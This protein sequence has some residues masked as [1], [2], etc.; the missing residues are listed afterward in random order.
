[1]NQ[2][3]SASW[4][5]HVGSL[6]T[7]QQSPNWIAAKTQE[8]NRGFVI[9][10]IEDTSEGKQ[11]LLSDTG[12]YYEVETRMESDPGPPLMGNLSKLYHFTSVASSVKWVYTARFRR[13]E[14][15]LCKSGIM[16]GT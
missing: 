13:L 3:C 4:S 1:M 7:G 15:T 2:R 12:V 16:P 8:G 6:S 14:E 9:P 5:L 11:R 10:T